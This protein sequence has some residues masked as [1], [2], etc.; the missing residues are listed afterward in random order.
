MA[1]FA[2][3]NSDVH[4]QSENQVRAREQLHV[5]HD[6]LV[7]FAFGDELIV[8]MRKRMRADGRDLQSASSGQRRPVCCAAR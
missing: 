8:P 7:T 5:F 2:I 4:V 3:R 1:R 6:F